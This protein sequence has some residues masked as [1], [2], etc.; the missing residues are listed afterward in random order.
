MVKAYEVPANL[1]IARLARYLKDEGIVKPPEWTKYVKTG[2]HAS[3][4][5]Q[6]KDWWYTRC[7]SLLRK[8]YMHGP[9]GLSDLESEYGGRQRR[10]SRPS[11]HRDAGGA[12]I[13]NALHQLE[14]A[15][16]V[17]KIDKKGRVLTS[18]GMEVVDRY[19]KEVFDELLNIIPELSRYA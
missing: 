3:R 4:V 19:A 18:K 6:D 1:L 14:D 17:S 11:H 8:I 13:R 2:A 10:G 9:I 15:G 12:I 7:A 16:Y 5:P